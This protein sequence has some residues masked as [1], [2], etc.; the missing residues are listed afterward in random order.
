MSPNKQYVLAGYCDSKLRMINTMSW[1]EVFAFD[2]ARSFENLDDSNSSADLNIYV[3]NETIDDG[4]LY[5]AV[6]KP[7]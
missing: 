7:Y 1:K 3:E 5:E 2:H 4:P 6:S